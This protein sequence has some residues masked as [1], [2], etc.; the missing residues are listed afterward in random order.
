[1]F[2]TADVLYDMCPTCTQH[3][4]IV[5]DLHMGDE[6]ADEPP[7]DPYEH[8][9]EMEALPQEE[10][11]ARFVEE[12]SKC[13]LCYACRNACP[14]CYC[15]VC[16]ADK[17]TPR[18]VSASATAEDVQFFQIMRT[19]HL[20]GRCVGCGACTRACPQGV[21]LRL[22]LDKLRQDVA[23]LYDYQAGVD[24]ED[25]PPLRTYRQDDYN[26]FVM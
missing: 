22:L 24:P 15:N 4:P 10:R 14:L 20:A 9:R 18:W 12:T 8:V 3:N 13:N 2:A 25:S 17:T 11:W 5:Y 26:D 23:E 1:M 19:F 6:I 7:Q 16:F 21:N